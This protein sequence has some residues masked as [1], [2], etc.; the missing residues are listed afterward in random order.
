MSNKVGLTYE[1]IDKILSK[2]L[3]PEKVV[4]CDAL[5]DVIATAII[6]NNE[7]LLKDINNLIIN[8]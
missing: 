2:A 3:T 5:R 7:K 4:D 6:K 8:K 1:Q